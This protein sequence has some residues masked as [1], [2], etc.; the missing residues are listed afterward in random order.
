MLIPVKKMKTKTKTKKGKTK[1]K[2]E[3]LPV[4]ANALFPIKKTRNREENKK[5]P[6]L[7]KES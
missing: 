3:V 6:L 7:V 2:W 5:D 1:Q 4:G